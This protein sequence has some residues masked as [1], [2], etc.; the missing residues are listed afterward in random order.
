MSVSNRIAV[1]FLVALVASVGG[2]AQACT[3]ILVGRAAT[4]DGS[5]LMATSCD[6][7]IMGRVYVLPAAEYPQGT[8]V[9]MFYDF[10]APSTWQE[11]VDQ[12]RR[13]YTPVGH[14]PI[15][16]TYRCIL[17]AG[18]LADSITGGMNE[19]GV[20]MG[21]EFMEMKPELSNRHGRVSTCSNHW[22]SSLIANG[23]L[24]ARTAREAI[25]LMGEMAEKHGFTY[26]WAPAAGCAIP[27]VDRQEAWIME[28]FG[29]GK[30]WTP[31]SGKPG[32]VWCAQRVPDGEATCN[33]NRSRIAEVDLDNPRGFLA[34]SNIHA[35]A[36]ELGLWKRG[37]R[38]VWHAVY[39]TAGGRGN[40]LREWAAF[41]AL[42]PALGLQAT[43]DPQQ[44]RY[45]FSV[46]VDG[47][48]IVPT[49]T[50][51]MRDC[52]QGT[53]FDV[54]AQPAFRP[55]GKRSPLARPVGSR[56][57]FDLLGVQPERCIS[58]ETS[59]Y[60]YVSQVREGL[61]AP[62]AGCL[63][64]TLGPAG[65]SCFAPV[66][67]GTRQI[68]ES[69]S[70]LP[71]FTRIAR[72]QVQWKFQ[73]V[74]DLTGLK[75]QEAI[76]D[77]RKVFG[78]AEEQFLTL[79]PQFEEAAV[80][81]FQEHGAASA[82]QFVTAYSNACLEK[83]DAAYGELVDFLTFKYLYSYSQAAPPSLP[84]VSPVAIPP[85]PRSQRHSR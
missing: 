58:T 22:T 61:P 56:D 44:D 32:A 10:P 81:M 62:V 66:Y 29:P 64:L 63:W 67:C 79:Q 76:E 47:K 30:D 21:I 73:L 51:V 34:S 52:Y 4:A 80:R 71:D 43:G 75:Y 74:E 40:S 26:Y 42:A 69:W 36:E 6:G 23:L 7:G 39:G 13:G 11:H 19:H 12:V 57:L 59:G 35:L 37:E 54:T 28:I 46:K 78:P 1:H 8:S 27:V 53:K 82:E 41:N 60:V 50:A 16:R 25:R 24:R 18:H 72:T 20:S 77:V 31:G 5:V 38:F 65:T 83:V 3:T 68:T 14:L 48:V 9:P 33:A 45:P 70:R 49:L 55:G 2:G 15:D 84:Q 17:V 85:M